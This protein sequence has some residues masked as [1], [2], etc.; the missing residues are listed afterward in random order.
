[1]APRDSAAARRPQRASPRRL[2]SVSR[3]R[4]PDRRRVRYQCARRRR[5]R[6]G[7]HQQCWDRDWCRRWCLPGRAAPPPARGARTVAR[8]STALAPPAASDAHRTI[9]TEQCH[10]LEAVVEVAEGAG[11]V[12]AA[13][14]T[15]RPA[16][17][18]ERQ[19]QRARA[20]KTMLPPCLYAVAPG[21]RSKPPLLLPSPPPSPPPPPATATGP[22]AEP[23]AAEPPVRPRSTEPQQQRVRAAQP[24]P[25]ARRRGVGP[26]WR[27]A[28]ACSWAH[29][30]AAWAGW[31]SGVQVGNIIRGPSPPT[32]V[33]PLVLPLGTASTRQRL[34][35]SSHKG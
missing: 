31:R 29:R 17:A 2:A 9:H 21:R 5:A 22:R 13:A 19:H 8:G 30:A 24:R 15:A 7:A 1:M 20:A 10:G 32:T 16:G 34:R 3:A 33:H 14:A 35:L 26:W 25:P 6:P 23:T 12:G 4:S 18:H 28:V 27:G 11:A